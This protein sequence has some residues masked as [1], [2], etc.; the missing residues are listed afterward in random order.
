MQTAPQQTAHSP[1]SF[2]AVEPSL[3]AVDPR[4]LGE[5][6][7]V[8]DVRRLLHEVIERHH[9]EL[10]WQGILH[11]VASA[12]WVLWLVWDGSV[13][14]VLATELYFD[15]GGMKR[16]RIPFCTGEG[17]RQWVHLLGQIEAWARDEGCRRLDMI[18]RKGWAKH[19]PDYRMT[20]V[21]LEKELG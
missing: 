16:C 9:G 13:R 17:A 5:V 10:S 20:H 3:V 1:T 15:V 14:A 11:K 2:S 4:M 12:E 6:V 19:L 7:A 18:A 8:P 21:V